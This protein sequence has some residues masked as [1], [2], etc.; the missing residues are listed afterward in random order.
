MPWLPR[1]IALMA[2]MAIGSW[3]L[4]AAGDGDDGAEAADPEDAAEEE[5][6]MARGIEEPERQ[7]SDAGRDFGNV[8]LFVPRH[9][10]EYL[11]W[12]TSAAVA[13][14]EKEPV[15]PR[16][17]QVLAAPGGR[18]FVLPTFLAE[19]GGLFNVGARLI[20]DFEHVAAGLRLGF[21]GPNSFEVEPRFAWR[22]PTPF[23]SVFTAEALY[24]RDND[25]DFLGLGQ[26]PRADSRNRYLP[27]QAGTEAQYFEER[28][29]WIMAYGMRPNDFIEVLISGSVDRRRVDDA[30]NSEPTLSQ[31]FEP[32]SVLGAFERYTVMYG[33]T[34]IRFDTRPTR[35]KPSAGFLAENY[36]GA[37]RGVSSLDTEL[38]RYGGRVAGFIPIYRTTNILSPTLIV[39][40][41]KPV[42]DEQ[43]PFA[44]LSRQPDFRGFD[45]RRDQLSLV[46]KVDYRW[47]IISQVA[48]RIFFDTALVA[49]E[50]SALD[51]SA[52]RWAAGLAIDLHSDSTE[53]GRLGFSA[54]PEGVRLLFALGVSTA[55]GD[56]Q[57]R[58]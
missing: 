23:R 10:V 6:R 11:Y 57:H 19:T 46:A 52:L 25:S 13:V 14:L 9:I 2:G 1:P 8:V 35:G 39:D 44:E 47:L 4:A 34:A 3:S 31:V 53:I 7:E 40:G 20:A 24:K 41:V 51:F 38:V 58:D 48:S 22:V 56:R 16:L 42:H 33:E 55:Y 37:G 45:T 28:A 15:V 27:G 36:V 49:P 18:L 26:D 5:A 21:G 54:G 29:R 30:R 32:G 12:G 50:W 17:Q 43:L